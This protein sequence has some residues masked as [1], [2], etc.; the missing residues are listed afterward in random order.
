MLVLLLKVDVAESE[1]VLLEP[2]KLEL[3]ETEPDITEVVDVLKIGVLEIVELEPV[4]PEVA[5]T[6]LANMVGLVGL[7]LV[8]LELS[9]LRPVIL[10]LTPFKLIVGIELD[11]L[12]SAVPGLV[13]LELNGSELNALVVTELELVVL[14]PNR[15]ELAEPR[16]DMVEL[17]ALPL[18]ESDVVKLPALVVKEVTVT[19]TGGNEQSVHVAEQTASMTLLPSAGPE[20]VADIKHARST[21]RLQK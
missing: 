16:P 18:W 21:R 12:D 5:V 11:V 3:A 6:E 13:M 7:K 9:E 17:K 15:L 8:G 10:E 2:N 20:E 1:L 19:V 4:V 14:K